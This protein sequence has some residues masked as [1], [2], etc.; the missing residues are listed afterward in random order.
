MD[1]PFYVD[2]ETTAQGGPKGDSP[3]AHWLNNEILLCG[4]CQDIGQIHINRTPQH[5][6]DRMRKCI[7]QGHIPIIIAHNAKFDLKYL[8]RFCSDDIWTKIKVWD[9]MTWQ[10]LNSGHEDKFISLDA[11][12]SKYNINF[13]K[14]LD[15]GALL[16]NGVRMQDIPEKDLRVYLQ[17]DVNVLLPAYAYQHATA[18]Y[19]M[20]YIIPLASMELNG[21][22]VDQKKW[23]TSFMRNNTELKK[24]EMKMQAH[25]MA[26]C[27]WVN[28]GSPVVED[29]FTDTVGL[30]SKYVKAFSRRTL[31]F[32]WTRVPM[33]LPITN[34]WQLGFKP[35]FGAFYVNNIPSHFKNPTN[36]GYV[37]DDPVLQADTSWIS[38]CVQKH[39]HAAKVVSTYLT[40]F[41][42]SMACQDNTVYPKLNTTAT[43]TGR[44]SSSG[45]NGQNI[46]PE[47]RNLIQAHGSNTVY[48]IDF[49]Q[50]EMVA[51]ACVSQ[52]PDMIAALNRGDDLHYLS[53]KTVMGWNTPF[54]MNDK[55]RKIVKAV[56]FGV[57]YGGKAAGLAKSTGVAKAKV[58]RII[59]SFYTTYPGVGRWQLKMFEDVVDNMYPHSIKDGVQRYASM[60]T[61]PI[62]GRLFKFIEGDAPRWIARKT[63]RPFSF[64]PTHT[65]N[66]PI[67]GFAGGDIVMYALSWLWRH[68]SNMRFIIT[69]H[70]SIVIESVLPLYQIQNLV[71]LMCYATQAHFN[72]PVNLHCDVD[73][74]THWK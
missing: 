10:Y 12:C 24:Q 65:S 7:K 60:Y 64:S 61:L 1:V 31:S 42:E 6:M 2:L 69:V 51:V 17:G 62:S 72:L 68:Q 71:K 8:M 74:G 4:W 23:Y 39:R 3:E 37:I 47:V 38:K 20:D 50:L 5:L 66:Y 49:K 63:G 19:F 43:N 53:G 41:W 29:D 26:C 28:D 48:E 45:P 56:N 21:L 32:L 15:L 13:K 36:L 46:P 25:I 73:G 35:A 33:T 16:A 34:K 67:Q 11:L 55:D 57:L 70:D 58:Q 30:K 40:P 52:C 44:L 18:T 27:E 54:D 22:Y 14:T 9:T 59:D